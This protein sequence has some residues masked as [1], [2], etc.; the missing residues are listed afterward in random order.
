M[1]EDAVENTIMT[2]RLVWTLIKALKQLAK[3]LFIRRWL[4]L[5]PPPPTD[6]SDGSEDLKS[7]DPE[8]VPQPEVHGR[9][10]VNSPTEAKLVGVEDL[11]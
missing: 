7:D 2:S 4:N 1:S 5:P 9:T 8:V 6:D 3:K 10:E 11:S